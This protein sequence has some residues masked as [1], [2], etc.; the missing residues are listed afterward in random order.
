MV[1]ANGGESA[2]AALEDLEVAPDLVLTDLRMPGMNGVELARRLGEVAPELRVLFMTGFP[3]EAQPEGVA[4]VPVLVKP[5]GAA[6]LA[7]AVRDRLDL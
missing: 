3:G 2:L 7:R 4:D 5:F 6:E 1:E